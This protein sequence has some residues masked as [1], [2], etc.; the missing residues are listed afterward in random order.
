MSRGLASEPR[1]RKG[2]GGSDEIR[3][4]RIWKQ[5]KV[6]YQEHK[7][8]KKYKTRPESDATGAMMAMNHP[9]P[10]Q[11]NSRHLGL[12]VT[13]CVLPSGT[14]KVYTCFIGPA[15]VDL[16]RQNAPR[17]PRLPWCEL[18]KSFPSREFLLVSPFPCLYKCQSGYK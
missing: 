13:V 6:R 4:L 3:L 10:L 16:A 8:N 12:H 5:D 1:V 2:F 14:N 17:I 18:S 7:S 15:H 11:T 9:S